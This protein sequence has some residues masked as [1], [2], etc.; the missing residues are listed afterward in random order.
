MASEIKVIEEAAAEQTPAS[1]GELGF[2][3]EAELE[4]YIQVGIDDIEAGRV[5]PHHVVV[6]QMDDLLARLASRR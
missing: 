6:A 1:F 2:A 5:V 3:S 4:A